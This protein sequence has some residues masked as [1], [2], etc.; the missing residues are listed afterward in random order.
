MYYSYGCT[1]ECYHSVPTQMWRSAV[2][3]WWETHKIYYT[4]AYQEIWVG[5]ALTTFV[6]YKISYGGKIYMF[7]F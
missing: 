4:Q 5:L 2:S 7:R 6:Y 1:S 3:R